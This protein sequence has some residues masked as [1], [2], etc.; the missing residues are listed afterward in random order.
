M[1]LIR[2]NHLPHLCVWHCV[3][4]NAG[5]SLCLPEGSEGIP[6]VVWVTRAGT[7]YH[8]DSDCYLQKG[9]K[10]LQ[11]DTACVH[12]KKKRNPYKKDAWK[13]T[14]PGKKEAGN[15]KL[16]PYCLTDTQTCYLLSKITT[17]YK[18][19]IG[20]MQHSHHEESCH[21]TKWRI[22]ESNVGAKTLCFLEGPKFPKTEA[23]IKVLK[24]P[25][26]YD[27]LCLQEAGCDTSPLIWTGIYI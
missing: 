13:S 16:L 21:L 4:G 12:F 1:F 24:I 17:S 5:K 23:F 8:V 14:R 9:G 20:M 19:V 18:K 10:L 3:G 11:L 7:C 25:P 15:Q 2:L 26:F 22:L 6:E 27:I